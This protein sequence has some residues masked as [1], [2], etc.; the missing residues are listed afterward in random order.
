MQSDGRPLSQ[1][2]V[3]EKRTLEALMARLRAAVEEEFTV[4]E[5]GCRQY[6]DNK[7]DQASFK[8]DFNK[9]IKR[10]CEESNQFYIDI[11][12]YPPASPYHLLWEVYEEFHPPK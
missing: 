4:Y 5:F 12:K 3:A 9:E 11:R 2:K 1:L 10:L 6:R 8:T 7:I